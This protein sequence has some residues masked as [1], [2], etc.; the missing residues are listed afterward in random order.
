MSRHQLYSWN[1][2]SVL[3]PLCQLTIPNNGRPHQLSIFT[4][5]LD[6]A[7]LVGVNGLA[8]EFNLI[9]PGDLFI[10]F[11]ALLMVSCRRYHFLVWAIIFITFFH[12]LLTFTSSLYI[13]CINHVIMWQ[14]HSPCMCLVFV[15]GVLSS[16]FSVV[17]CLP[18]LT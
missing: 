13:F 5:L 6:F 8:Y 11:Q 10:C 17:E 2:D 12:F 14:M 3:N 4:D 1:T 16:R 9:F 7:S 15:Y 18:L